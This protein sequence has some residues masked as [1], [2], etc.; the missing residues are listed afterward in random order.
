MDLAYLTADLPGSGGVIRKTPEDFRVTEIPLYEASGRGEFLFLHVRKRAMGTF[1]AVRRLSQALR[2]PER[3]IGYAG[4]K[5]ARAVTT[6]WVS[7]PVGV[8]ERVR[9]LNLQGLAVED[10]RRHG[11][12][13]RVGHLRGNRFSIV[14]RNAAPGGVE[15]AAAV[16]DVLLRRGAPNYFGEQR[17]G[18]RG[19][20]HLYGESL[21]RQ[22]Y[23]TF[24][25]RFLGGPPTGERDPRLIAS[26][27]AFE[28][29]RLEEAYASMPMNH[30]SE[31]KCLHALLRFGDPER[32][33]LAIPKRM[34]QMYVSSFQS[35]LFNRALEERI[36]GIDR[37]EDGDLAFVHR[38]YKVF[39]VVDAATE[40]PRCT[41]LEISPS[42]PIFG[43]RTSL[44]EGA[45]GARERALL[46]GAGLDL[47]SFE[48]RGG[49]RFD[50]QR[51]PFRT[52]LKEAVLAPLGKNA[53]RLD[54]VLASGS[55]ATAVL[56][57]ILKA[58]EGP[59]P[60]ESQE[61]PAPEGGSG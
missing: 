6:Q 50:G 41:A 8:E 33:C 12:K 35:A 4:L 1:E 25:K 47:S 24:L 60:A 17:F 14:V 2:I 31:K 18:A 19:A 23:E 44:P 58:P 5:D 32:A 37:L 30:R 42:G 20:S 54:F 16:L 46:A 51:R 3:E 34:R 61:G 29:G 28:A 52:L 13:L 27:E 10:I 56:R 43:S 45:P 55:F 11:N 38:S 59:K 26:R 48:P 49:L 7:V 40:Q 15:R 39:P 9:A 57:E 21:L 36:S 22:D 53:F